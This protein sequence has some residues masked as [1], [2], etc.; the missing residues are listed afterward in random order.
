MR[1]RKIGR[2]FGLIEVM[3]SLVV[4]SV[5]G[6]A[7]IKV[8]LGSLKNV[9]D[10]MMRTIATILIHDMSGRMQANA[11]ELWNGM[12]AAYLSSAAASANT[13]CYG[14]KSICTSSTMAANDLF[15]WQELIQKSFPASTGSLV[16]TITT[17]VGPAVGFVCLESPLAA[18]VVPT[19]SPGCTNA[20]TAPYPLVFTIKIYWKSTSSSTTYDQV[21]YGTVEAPVLS[22][23]I[24]PSTN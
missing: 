2:G 8:Q 16:N 17:S 10:T 5:G 19:T 22:A 9:S 18:P 20:T 24:Y 4:I 21:Q 15:E 11:A 7:Y 3:I 13:A 12:G 6:L 1:A 14:S 23:P